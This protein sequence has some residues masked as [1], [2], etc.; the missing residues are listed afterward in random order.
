MKNFDTLGEK[1]QKTF[2]VDDERFSDTNPSAS[3]RY[4]D[5]QA[6]SDDFSDSRIQ[7]DEEQEDDA[8][9]NDEQYSDLEQDQENSYIKINDSDTKINDN[10][11]QK[12]Y[13]IPPKPKNKR[14]SPRRLDP[15]L[16]RTRKNS[17]R[18]GDIGNYEIEENPFQN[19]DRSSQRSFSNM[20]GTLTPNQSDN[21]THN[22]SSQV[23]QKSSK[24]QNA[25]KSLNTSFN[26]PNLEMATE[27]N[28]V[29]EQQPRD[30]DRVRSFSKKPQLDSDS[31]R[32]GQA[33]DARRPNQNTQ[34][35]RVSESQ[36]DEPEELTPSPS[37]LGKHV[38]KM[39]SMPQMPEANISLEFLPN[40]ETQPDHGGIG[41]KKSPYDTNH[42]YSRNN[43][44]SM[45]SLT[46]IKSLDEID[47]E[48]QG[49]LNSI[50]P[51]TP[52]PK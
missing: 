5:D 37:P 7:G 19:R 34:L 48:S 27:S 50:S 15:A 21:L 40:V 35:S 24:I 14:N 32:L 49:R 28:Q 3:P 52:N 6:R 8:Y 46:P 10:N 12:F 51:L 39:E 33:Y 43:S 18:K 42:V 20:S 29:F 25:L 26:M 23:S 4:S 1:R 44:P 41:N 31:D 13:G 45:R 2:P 47:T 16:N 22:R 11:Q 9:V 17:P 38:Q 30:Q 36:F